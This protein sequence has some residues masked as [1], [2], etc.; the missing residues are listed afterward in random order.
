M[1]T[2]RVGRVSRESLPTTVWV[3]VGRRGGRDVAGPDRQ[4]SND[5]HCA[6]SS[7]HVVWDSNPQPF[8]SASW[9][10]RPRIEAEYP[11]GG[12]RPEG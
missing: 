2:P 3:Q 5:E 11:G 10:Y 9:P 1:F 6:R 4:R 8:L 7:W 12:G